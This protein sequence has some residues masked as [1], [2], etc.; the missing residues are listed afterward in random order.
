MNVATLAKLARSRQVPLLASLARGLVTPVYRASF[1]AAAA[2]N[3]VL[4]RLA[5]RPC[6]LDTLA[7]ALDVREDRDVL[8]AWLDIGVRLGE[9]GFDDGC[10]KLRGRAA[11][12]L[13]RSR[14]DAIAAALEEVTR[15]HLPVLLEAPAIARGGK[16]LTLRDQDGAVIARSTQVVRPFV[17]EAVD[18]VVERHEP[19]RLLEVGCGSGVYARHAALLNPRLTALAIDLQ[20]D[21]AAEAAANMAAWGLADRVDVRRADVRDLDMEPVFDLVTMHNNIYYFPTD[22]RVKVL[23]RV[24]SLLAPGGRL[25]LTTPC[26]GGPVGMEVLDL[27]FSCADFGGPLPDAAELVDQLQSAGFTSVRERRLI[28]GGEFRAFVGTHRDPEHGT[29]VEELI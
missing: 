10:Y 17:E 24:R 28:P 20:D 25:L 23:E 12:A 5:V 19:R 16:R 13:G 22:E 27:W 3:G 11:K 6:D 18:L 4:Q 29:D 26:R 21:V 8:R 1:L 9:L 15:F 14:N 7:N 2:G